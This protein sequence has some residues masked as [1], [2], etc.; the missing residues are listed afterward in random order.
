MIVMM[1]Y[2]RS[3]EEIN[4]MDSNSLENCLIVL[5][6]GCFVKCTARLMF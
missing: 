3:S 1:L 4:L 5:D 2:T 6:K